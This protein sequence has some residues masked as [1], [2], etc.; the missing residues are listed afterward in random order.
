M[1]R[2]PPDWAALGP[3]GR[4]DRRPLRVAL[5][6]VAV[7]DL[8]LLLRLALRP[9]G[10]LEPIPGPWLYQALALH[11]AWL[12]V[13]VGV[14]AFAA[15]RFAQRGA[16]RWAS[17]LLLAL[18]LCEETAGRAFRT[19]P[20]EPFQ[21][22]V[23]LWGWIVGSLWS[24][25]ARGRRAGPVYAEDE[26]GADLGAV[27]ACGISYGLAAFAK[28][29]RSGADWDHRLIWHVVLS[30]QPVD[31]S[32]PDAAMAAWLLRHPAVSDGLAR[33][34]IALQLGGLLLPL[35][36]R[37]RRL[38]ATGLVSLHLGM[39]ALGRLLDPEVVT[40][41]VVWA[42]LWPGAGGVG[43]LRE[44]ISAPRAKR[45]VVPVVALCVALA[46][47]AWLGPVR[48]WM[49]YAPILPRGPFDP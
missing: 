13:V 9:S 38:A 45:W 16:L 29:A 20:P 36:P 37:L 47:V 17:V 35:G 12:G 11:G 26:I 4:R 32:G 10:S 6:T 40:L 27:A 24:R 21:P 18:H 46:A 33:A 34:S 48:A 1:T 2:S 39:L 28:L 25:Y 44:P 43:A 49:A 41:L 31:G 19:L 15:L 3:W 5:A 23:F 22:G 42:R 30:G 8:V 7:Y 14:G